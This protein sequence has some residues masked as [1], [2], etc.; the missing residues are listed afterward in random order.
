MVLDID[1]TNG[2]LNTN[3]GIFQSSTI[4]SGNLNP[5]N[6]QNIFP[7]IPK[8][9]SNWPRILLFILV[10]IAL[11]GIGYFLYKS[12]QISKELGFKFNIGEVVTTKKPELKRIPQE[13]TLM[14]FLLVLTVEKVAISQILTQ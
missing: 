7:D 1:L 5:T 6:P 8:K 13:D 10:G 2:D 9:K 14:Y 3:P 12:S 11:G 4:E